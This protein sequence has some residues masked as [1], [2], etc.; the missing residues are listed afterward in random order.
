MKPIP[1]FRFF[2]HTILFCAIAFGTILHSQAQSYGHDQN[3]YLEN[4]S[5]KDGLPFNTLRNLYGDK[6]G[7]LWV[8]SANSLL[9]YD[10]YE[11]VD[12]P[13]VERCYPGRPAY[14]VYEEENGDLWFPA[15]LTAS[16]VHYSAHRGIAYKMFLTNPESDTLFVRKILKDMNG[17]LLLFCVDSISTQFYE[18]SVSFV[19]FDTRKL[20]MPQEDNIITTELSS[21][22]VL[23]VFKFPEQYGEVM[24]VAIDSANQIWIAC[25]KGLVRFDMETQTHEVLISDRS[26]VSLQSY[27]DVLWLGGIREI[28][29]Y[30]PATREKMN[31]P[32]PSEYWDEVRGPIWFR[33]NNMSTYENAILVHGLSSNQHDGSRMFWFNLESKT[34]TKIVEQKD[35]NEDRRSPV[36]SECYDNWGNYWIGTSNGNLYKY[37]FEKNVFNFHSNSLVEGGIKGDFNKGTALFEDEDGIIWIGSSDGVL[38]KWDR[39]TGTIEYYNNI[40][41][42]INSLTAGEI[43]RILRD[44]EGRL[45]VATME[46]LNLQLPDGRFKRY[47]HVP[48]DNTSLKGDVIFYLFEDSKQNLWVATSYES[49]NGSKALQRYDPRCDCFVDGPAKLQLWIEQIMEDSNG[50]LWINHHFGIGAYDFE[51]DIYQ[52]HVLRPGMALISPYLDIKGDFWLAWNNSQLTR[53]SPKDDI[54]FEYDPYD[55]YPGNP[56]RKVVEDDLGFIWI[57]CAAGMIQLDPDSGDPVNVFRP[58]SWMPENKKWFGE[59]MGAIKTKDG[60]IIVGSPSGILEFDP[61]AI[62]INQRAPNSAITKINVNGVSWHEHSGDK[63]I[64]RAFRDDIHLEYDENDLEIGYTGLH[65]KDPDLN[66]FAYQLTGWDSDWI[67]AGD[68]RTASYSS[69]PPGDYTFR[70]KASNSDGVWMNDDDAVSLNIFIAPPLWATWW[71]YSIYVLTGLAG[72]L[73]LRHTEQRAQKN[74]LQREQDIN[75]Q[76]RRLDKLKDQ[77]LANTSHELRTPLNGI[78]GI[79]ESLKDGVAG[80]LPTKA[81][82]NLNLIAASGRR[83]GVLVNDILDFSK[84]KNEDITL[85]IKPIDMRAAVDVVLTLSQAIITNDKLNLINN[86]AADVLLVDADENRVQQILHNLIGNA[87]KFTA[88]GSVT[89]SSEVDGKSMRISIRDTGVGIDPSKHDLIFESFEQ[90][91][92]STARNYGG[93]GLGLT[94]TRQLVELHGGQISVSS[95]LGKGSK[96]TFSLPISQSDRSEI[97]KKNVSTVGR[98]LAQSLEVQPADG[99]SAAAPVVSE[100]HKVH[101][102]IVD[103]EPTNL[104][105]L[106]NHLTLA[107]YSPTRAT[108]GSEALDLVQNSG[109]FDLVILDVMMPEK[110][111]Y[112]VCRELR[113]TFLPSQ[114]PVIMLTAKNM[115]SDL[116]D[117]FSAGANDYLTKPFSKD[118]LLSRV[119]THLSLHRIHRS[120]GKYMPYE[121]LKSIGRESIEDVR[122][123][124]HVQKEVTVLFSDIR[125]FTSLAEQISPKENFDV[126]NQYAAAMG[127][128]I[129]RNAGFVNQYL[130][131][132]IMAIFPGK[133][134]DALNAAVEMQKEV[135][136]INV[137]LIEMIPFPI[138]IGIGLHFGKLIMGIIGDEE[139]NSAAIVAD[140]VNTASRME[141]L[142]KHYNANIIVS[143]RFVEAMQDEQ[144]FK[145]RYL[146]K[147]QL[148]GKSVALGIYEC[149]DSD[150]PDLIIEKMRHMEQFK[151]GLE[152]YYRKEFA[153]SAAIFDRIVKANPSDGVAIIFRNESAQLMIRGAS[154]DW[155]GITK[156]DVK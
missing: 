37:S 20:V 132:G 18:R 139:R 78:I 130:G 97:L 15:Y 114:L 134:D 30:N 23:S 72:L 148:K 145:M 98:P 1:H 5:I 70:V 79:A 81:V 131:D 57:V 80:K 119:K 42:D 19:L 101:I 143:E 63:L 65:L 137:D 49:W 109:P 117:G 124:D 75:Q 128:I 4:F 151:K 31:Y 9:R 28:S 3:V 102:L 17:L 6:E 89:V 152:H 24:D 100:Q 34:F 60:H 113:S 107:G 33:W 36:L 106:D 7:Y 156:L 115:V 53:Y 47:N 116:V 153:E 87:I 96:F 122:L 125:D 25:D 110:S 84:L 83:L 46:G 54:Q 45:W 48:G 86:I 67:H 27:Q 142:T 126:I 61:G 138:R 50:V 85:Q 95:E 43:W 69:L 16:A 52:D 88:S 93:T 77:F 58:Q 154:E 68:R 133:H 62:L 10:G 111:G 12:F 92:G 94:V 120:T 26:F 140:T 40:P 149:F 21:E 35:N 64:Q 56:I 121:F 155:T 91:D 11:F 105:V 144:T 38:N 73:W 123:G 59:Y 44:S 22:S 82:F 90:G 146:G 74:K 2:A 136:R 13:E 118:E 14:G 135:N 99:I 103:D 150:S 76:L 127:P 147:V 129:R 141:G 108:S 55:L 29:C 39:T 8:S 32:F 41:G 112:D 66:Q 104:Q 71:A 51:S